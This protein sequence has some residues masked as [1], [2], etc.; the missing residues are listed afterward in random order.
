MGQ[1]KDVLINGFPRLVAKLVGFGVIG[2]EFLSD[3]HHG[4]RAEAVHAVF[5]GEI[6]VEGGFQNGDAYFFHV[7]RPVNGIHGPE[8]FAPKDERRGKRRPRQDVAAFSTL[9]VSVAQKAEQHEEHV[10][11]VK[12]QRERAK[13]RAAAHGQTVVHGRAFAHHAELL[14]VEG[15]KAGENNHAK[16]ADG[17]V[18]GG[19][20]DEG[21]DDAGQQNAPQPH[22]HEAAHARKVT[23]GDHAE[24]AHAAE[25]ACGDDEGL[26]HGRAGVHQKNRAEKYAHQHGVQQEQ[27]SGRA[28]GKRVHSGGDEHGQAD[29]GHHEQNHH[30][31]VGKQELHDG[32]VG[33]REHGRQSGD[34]ESDRHPE[35]DLLHVDGNAGARVTLHLVAGSVIHERFLPRGLMARFTAT[36]L[37][38]H[39]NDKASFAIMQE[40]EG[41]ENGRA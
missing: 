21:V 25:H 31:G 12:V 30:D 41:G 16:H 33:G 9:V 29:D 23:L 38:I 35:I 6:L 3:R 11:K 39:T 5:S 17:E 18:H 10:D 13:Q 36:I 7:E 1:R 14:G 34:A 28:R 22:D 40:A 26:R 20:A 24:H 19:I 37:R 27:A 8:G 2:V 32:H 15:G 4:A